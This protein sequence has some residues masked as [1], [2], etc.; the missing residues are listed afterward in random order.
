[1]NR[2]I[3]IKGLLFLPLLQPALAAAR[4]LRVGVDV[5]PYCNMTILDARYAAQL[6]STTGKVH[7]YDD[8][9]CMLDHLLGYGGPRV[10]SREVYVADYAASQR[11][12]PRFLPAESAFFL[13]HERIR[14]P[15]GVGLLAFGSQAAL[16][17]YLRQQPQYQGSRLRWD[18]LLARG[19]KQ[20]W[21][22]GYGR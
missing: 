7:L 17:G 20:A 3:L 5:C 2:R 19:R 16:E 4:P 12:E 14:T 15:M 6:I 21:V 10:A 11:S 22:P 13:Y 1:M 9:G 8:L 18:E